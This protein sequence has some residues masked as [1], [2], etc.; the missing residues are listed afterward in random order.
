MKMTASLIVTITI[1]SI[2]SGFG[3]FEYSRLNELK[4]TAPKYE[5]VDDRGQASLRALGIA[6]EVNGAVRESE[7]LSNS[8]YLPFNESIVVL[9]KIP[10]GELKVNNFIAYIS[11]NG[12]PVLHRLIKKTDEGWVAAGDNNRIEDSTLVTKLNYLGKLH[13]PII[14]WKGAL[15]K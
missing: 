5:V 1:L 2:V 4:R 9:V 8:I 10:Y 13:E 11:N 15:I 6:F 14:T 7:G 12:V 3:I